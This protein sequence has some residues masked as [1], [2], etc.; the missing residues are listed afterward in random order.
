MKVVYE[1]QYPA[2]VRFKDLKPGETFDACGDIA[3]KTR[4]DHAVVLCD[5]NYVYRDPNDLVTPLNAEV[6][7]L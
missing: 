3:I 4:S 2:Q 7:V 1:N 5:G 6:R